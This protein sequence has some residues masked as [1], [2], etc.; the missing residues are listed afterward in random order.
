MSIVTNSEIIE[1]INKKEIEFTP[2]LDSF[3]L[4]AHSIDLRLG[5]TFMVPRMWH[6][7]PAGRTS[8]DITH[9]DKPK[10]EQF[11][12]VELES[13]QYFD[14]LPNE[15]ILAS[16][17]E[18][19][20]IPN[21]LMAV[22]YPRSSTNRKGLAVDLTGIID[23]GYEGQLAIPIRNNNPSRVV[24]LYPGERIC[25]IVLNKLDAVV[26]PRQSKYHQKDIIEGFQREKRTETN[27]VMK[28]N[29]K[30]LKKNYPAVSRPNKTSK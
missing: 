16:T 11:D 4:H 29:M 7:T 21:D 25:Q 28:G 6:L 12:V 9:F 22:L 13:G 18:S 14:L 10:S 15:Y 17:L 20:K 3:Q 1:R 30:D 5:F 26:K 24:R 27:L 19:V 2:P 8:L 23:A